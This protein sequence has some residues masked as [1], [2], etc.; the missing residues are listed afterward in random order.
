[1]TPD[2]IAEEA[3]L[4]L[5]RLQREAAVALAPGARPKL[6]PGLE[7]EFD[8]DRGFIAA[9]QEYKLAA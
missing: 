5:S 7:Q 1:M 6:T 8:L 3:L 2:R 9:M 4:D